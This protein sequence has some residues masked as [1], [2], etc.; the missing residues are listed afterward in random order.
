M[1]SLDENLGNENI[2]NGQD[3]IIEYDNAAIQLNNSFDSNLNNLSILTIYIESFGN[4]TDFSFEQFQN[5]EINDSNEHITIFTQGS[6]ND[7]CLLYE[8]LNDDIPI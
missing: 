8:L 6:A 1:N 3:T 2:Q 7:T 4:I 5:V